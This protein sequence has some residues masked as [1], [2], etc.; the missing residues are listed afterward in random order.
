M[1]NLESNQISDISPLVENGAL[2]SGADL[3][4]AGNNLDLT[5]DSDD[6]VNVRTLE[7]RG[8]IVHLLDFAPVEVD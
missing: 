1:L 8:V 3:W 6:M 7:A 4:L 2:A 5:E